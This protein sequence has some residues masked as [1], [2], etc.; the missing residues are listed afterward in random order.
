[1]SARVLPSK[2]AGA[3]ERMREKLAYPMYVVP[4]PAFLEM[5]AWVPHQ[6]ALAAGMLCEYDHATSAAAALDLWASHRRLCSCLHWRALTQSSPD[7]YS[8]VPTG[9]H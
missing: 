9:L 1:M 3:W 8:P 5:D 2:K 4:V 6:E 7:R